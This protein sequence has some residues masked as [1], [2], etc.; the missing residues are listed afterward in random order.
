[1]EMKEVRIPLLADPAQ[2]EVRLKQALP[3]FDVVRWCIS[4]VEDGIAI[5]EAVTQDIKTKEK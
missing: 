1:M 2:Y 4:H 3:G 5:V